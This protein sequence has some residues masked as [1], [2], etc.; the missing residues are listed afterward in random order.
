MVYITSGEIPIFGY[1]AINYT[2]LSVHE[3]MPAGYD[4]MELGRERIR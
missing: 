4:K 3:D 2:P 1:P